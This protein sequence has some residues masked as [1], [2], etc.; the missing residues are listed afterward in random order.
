[1]AYLPTAHASVGTSIGILVR[2]REVPAVVVKTPFYKRTR[3]FD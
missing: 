3:T 1:L 2:G